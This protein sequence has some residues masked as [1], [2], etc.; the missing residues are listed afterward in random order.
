MIYVAL[1]ML[2]VLT[3]GLLLHELVT[4]F[5]DASMLASDVIPHPPLV[6]PRLSPRCADDVVRKLVKTVS[7]QTDLHPPPHVM[8]PTTSLEVAGLESRV[9]SSLVSGIFT[10]GMLCLKGVQDNACM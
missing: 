3:L 1:Y 6:S 10:L 8:A 9:I 7:T 5:R 2:V 4:A